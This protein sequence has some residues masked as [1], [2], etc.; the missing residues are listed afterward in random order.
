M[1]LSMYFSYLH[2]IDFYEMQYFSKFF[3]ENFSQSATIYTSSSR[4]T[5]NFSYNGTSPDFRF[6]SETRAARKWLFSE[7]SIRR[8]TV[9]RRSFCQAEGRRVEN[10]GN[11]R[12]TKLSEVFANCICIHQADL[13]KKS[14]ARK[15]NLHIIMQTRGFT[16]DNKYDNGVSE[17]FT[18]RI[19][20]WTLF[21]I[22]PCLK[23]RFMHAVDQ[24]FQ[25][26]LFDSPLRVRS[27]FSSLRQCRKLIFYQFQIRYCYPSYG[28]EKPKMIAWLPRTSHRGTKD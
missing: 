21:K 24:I 4:F 12:A 28:R 8:R 19:I 2:L 27:N 23:H 22:Q 1:F 9:H 16:W 5:L 3:H 13:L 15:R 25:R 18:C 7:A 10:R 11:F 6:N 26:A 17:N 14:I 20:L